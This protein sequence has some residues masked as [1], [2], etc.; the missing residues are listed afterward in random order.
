MNSLAKMALA[1]LAFS[2]FQAGILAQTPPAATAPAATAANAV[3]AKVND[4]TVSQVAVNRALNAIPVA[5]REKSRAD[6]LQHLIE[7]LLID[8]YLAAL[9]IA[10]EPK[11]VDAQIEA[12]K[13]EIKKSEQDYATVLK[14]IELT[15]AELKEQIFNQLRWEHFVN[16]HAT[17]KVLLDMFNK[18]PEGFDNSAVRARHILIPS[19]NTEKEQKEAL[20]KLQAIKQNINAQVTAEMAKLPEQIDNVTKAK[21]RDGLVDEFFAAAAKQY[22]TCPSKNAGG[23]L[24]WFPRI[25]GMVEPFAKAAFALKP[26][27]MSEVVATQF[28]YH[29]ILVTDKKPGRPVKFGDVKEEVKEVYSVKLREAVIA[30]MKPQAKIEITPMK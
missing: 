11:E 15:E 13:L 16:E 5:D 19:G 8:Q 22:S 6:V 4:Q 30:K 12:F 1:T 23:D 28:G 7:N 24:M 21:K 10:V 27:E 17:E 14:K 9:K 25:G 26:F 18:I 3:A 20:A 2:F 29:L